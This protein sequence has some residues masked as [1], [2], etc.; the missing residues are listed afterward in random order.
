MLRLQI[1][2][3]IRLILISVIT[4]IITNS[5]AAAQCPPLYVFTGKAEGD[6]FGFSVASA[7]DVNNDGYDDLIV[8]AWYNDA[9]GDTAGGAY[10][11]SGLEG[12]TLYVFTGEAAGD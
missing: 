6:E 4:I 10:V 1:S 8:G 3:F 5:F 2:R 12:E 7:G 11:F 9:G